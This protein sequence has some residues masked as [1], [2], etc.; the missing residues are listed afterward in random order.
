MTSYIFE[1]D[2]WMLAVQRDDP[3]VRVWVDANARHFGK[4]RLIDLYALTDEKE[5]KRFA[6]KIGANILR[7]EFATLD[8]ANGQ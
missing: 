5:A 2:G 1:K 4:N 3:E 7:V 8:E 6:K